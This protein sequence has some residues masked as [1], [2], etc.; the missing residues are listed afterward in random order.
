[1]VLLNML[2]K[3]CPELAYVKILSEKLYVGPD[4]WATEGGTAVIYIWQ[5]RN[6]Q[7]TKEALTPWK[8]RH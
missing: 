7:D 1:M 6:A 3:M 2:N 8:H 4:T 5:G